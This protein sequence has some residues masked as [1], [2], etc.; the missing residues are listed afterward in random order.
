MFPIDDVI[1]LLIFA[2]LL[3]SANTLD[4]VVRGW[5][6]G[7][8]IVFTILL[9]ALAYA[10]NPRVH[11]R[12]FRVY[13]SS[14]LSVLYDHSSASLGFL[15]ISPAIPLV[16]FGIVGVVPVPS[17][18]PEFSIIY[19]IIIGLIVALQFVIL[20]LLYAGTENALFN[21]FFPQLSTAITLPTAPDSRGIYEVNPR[22]PRLFLA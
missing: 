15:G 3:S 2:L 13:D 11:R 22:P 16:V 8:G 14:G 9:L 4:R 5:V 6:S 7:L 19:P 12:R 21:E 20:H 18:S 10:A 1:S 17:T